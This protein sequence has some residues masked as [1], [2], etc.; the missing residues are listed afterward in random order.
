[1]ARW[2]PLDPVVACKK[3]VANLKSLRG[4]YL[5]CGLRDEFALHAGTRILAKRLRA[6]GLKIV[7]E[8]FEDGHMGISYR[9]DHS[10]RWLGKWIGK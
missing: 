1:M 7:H 2:R 3:H 9:Y 10:F 4:I 5:D 8:E 6:L